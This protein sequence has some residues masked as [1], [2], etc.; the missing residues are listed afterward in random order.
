MLGTIVLV[1]LVIAVLLAVVVGYAATRP[2]NFEVR[3]SATI[4]APAARIYPLIDDFHQWAR[5]SPWEERDPAMRRDFS[6]A[7]SG[8][9][10]VYAW[11][12]NGKIGAG[13]MEITEASP[14]TKIAIKLDFSRPFEGHNVAEF[15]LVP[16][17]QATAVTWV[18]RGPLTLMM[19]V[20]HLFMNMDRMVGGDFEAGLAKL[21]AAAET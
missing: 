11:D 8:R 1:A 17:G 21:K 12:G 16:N 4:N 6:G 18:M 19:K 3:R 14:Q 20:M 7:A 13:R 15:T 9:G 5:W 2:G 10:A